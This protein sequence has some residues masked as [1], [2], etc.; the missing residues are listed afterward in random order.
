MAHRRSPTCRQCCSDSWTKTSRIGTVVTLRYDRFVAMTS[1]DY[2]T[3][4]TIY[5]SVSVLS[6]S[7]VSMFIAVKGLLHSN[8]DCLA[9][10]N[11]I[12]IC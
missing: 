3:I 7:E 11:D 6:V 8:N 5:L 12:S 10:V 2:R 4:V 1:I 9:A